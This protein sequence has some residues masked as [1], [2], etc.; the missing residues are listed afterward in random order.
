MTN[1]AC[2][3]AGYDLMVT[4]QVRF[5]LMN[6]NTQRFTA[7]ESIICSLLHAIECYSHVSRYELMCLL[8]SHMTHAAR[9]LTHTTYITT[10]TRVVTNTHCTYYHYVSVTRIRD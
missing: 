5:G 4:L 9:V 10:H 8:C 7:L 3:R 2:V 1:V 6:R